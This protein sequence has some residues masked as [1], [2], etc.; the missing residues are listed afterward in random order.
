MPNQP[1]R[2][3]DPNDIRAGF[4]VTGASLPIG[5]IVL[6]KTSPAIAN[7]VTLCTSDTAAYY[8]VAMHEIADDEWGDIQIRGLALVR[9]GAAVAIG[10]R[11]MSD[12]TGEG[13][14]ATSGKN[15]LGIA[16]QVGADNTLFEVELSGPGGASVVP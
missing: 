8:G 10:D 9:G 16:M 13:I 1:G 4:N 11:V 2:Q 5:S 3:V 14:T 15:T 6:V 12:G 7:E